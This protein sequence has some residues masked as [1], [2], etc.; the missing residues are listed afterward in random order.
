M[1]VQQRQ[2]MTVVILRE[3]VARQQLAQQVKNAGPAPFLNSVPDELHYVDTQPGD[4]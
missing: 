3:F 2:E 4:L 1:S